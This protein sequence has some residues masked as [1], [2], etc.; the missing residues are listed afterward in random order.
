MGSK[1]TTIDYLLSQMQD[2]G[3]VSA[4]K[5]FG[6]YGVYCDGRMIALVCDDQFYLKPTDAGRKYLV[7]PEEGQPYPGAKFWF[8]I[9]EDS[10]DDSLWFTELIR[11]TTQEVPLPKPKKK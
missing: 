5:M 7:N 8:L 2:A 1:Q 10:W 11:L 3:E 4:K 6:E 9:P